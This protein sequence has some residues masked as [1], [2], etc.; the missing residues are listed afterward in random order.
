MPFIE[1]VRQ[2]LPRKDHRNLAASL[3]Q[4]A[5]SI[6]CL[7][8][9]IAGRGGPLFPL[10]HIREVFEQVAPHKELPVLDSSVHLLFTED[11]ATVSGPGLSACK[12]GL[13]VRALQA[14]RAHTRHRSGEDATAR[15][16]GLRPGTPRCG[17]FPGCI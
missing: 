17:P 14:M 10:A 2:R 11:L 9:V 4:H 13:A 3:C 5:R 15:H 16:L 8:T 1:H 12:L 6:T 7:V